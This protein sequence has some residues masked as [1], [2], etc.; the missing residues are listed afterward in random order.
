M[1][2]GAGLGDDARLAHPGGEQHLSQRVVELVSAG[3]KKVLALQRDLRAARELRQARRESDGRGPAGVVVQELARA[4]GKIGLSRRNRS[5]AASSSVQR[6][7]ERLGSEPSSVG[8]EV[9]LPPRLSGASHPPPAFRRP[10]R[11]QDAYRPVG[12]LRRIARLCAI[13][14][15]R[16]GFHARGDVDGGRTQSSIAR[17]TFSGVEPSGEDERHGKIPAGEKIPI[18]ARSRAASGSRPRRVEEDRRGSAA[19]ISGDGTP[20]H[21]LGPGRRRRPERAT[22]SR[23]SRRRARWIWTRSSRAASTAASI[24]SSLSSTKTP[25]RATPGRAGRREPRRALEI[26][27]ARRVGSEDEADVGGPETRRRDPRP[28]GAS[29]RRS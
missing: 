1:L 4:R 19:S 16:L 13:L 6:R 27:A 15:S 29:T 3:V 20:R 22:L 2:P 14:D 10:P 17:P 9:A 8:T 11:P 7:H 28:P 21:L 5:N 25:T 24:A 12:P 23:S 26:D 18:E